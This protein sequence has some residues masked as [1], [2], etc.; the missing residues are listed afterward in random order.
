MKYWILLIMS[1]ISLKSNRLLFKELDAG[2]VSTKYVDWMN[3]VEINKNLESR[4][5]KNN[6]ETIKK[7]VS[8]VQQ[9]RKSF[10]FGI[11]ESD[12]MNH[13]GNIKLG[14]I[15]KY[16]NRSSIGLVIGDKDSWGRGYATESIQSI[17]N[18]GFKQMKLVKIFASCY[19]NNIA[20]K[21]AFEKAGY[22]VEGFFSNYV[23]SST[24]RE[25]VWWMG[26]SVDEN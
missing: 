11:Y 23:N 5:V 7:F 1:S 15:N 21:I 22:K 26:I 17:T 3:D 8:Q 10:L 19:E 2:C 18:F 24:G 13:I 25:G 6:I 4:F 16:H 12:S 20:S 14:P 9:D